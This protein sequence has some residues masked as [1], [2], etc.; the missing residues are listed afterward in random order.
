MKFLILTEEQYPFNLGGGTTYLK[1]LT[2]G[3]SYHKADYKVLSPRFYPNSDLKSEGKILNTGIYLRKYRS[4]M[5]RTLFK[6]YYY[7]IWCLSVLLHLFKNKK[8]REFDIV[9]ANEIIFS[10]PLSIIIA[11][12]FRK[13]A[14]LIMHGKYSEAIKDRKLV[15]KWML[16]FISALEKL[17]VSNVSEVYSV[18]QEIANYYSKYNSRSFFFP[19]FIDLSLYKRRKFKSLQ[20][21]AYIGRLSREKNID[22]IIRSAKFFPDKTFL[23]IGDGPEENNLKE[24]ADSLKLENV[25][26]LGRRDDVPKLHR[27]IDL[28]VYIWPNES[29]GLSALE[30]MASGIPVIAADTN[31]MHYFVGE[32]K[33]GVVIKNINISPESLSSAIRKFE[34]KKFY[35][36]C[37]NNA[38]KTAKEYDYKKSVSRFLRELSKIKD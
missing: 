34:N 6:V 21:I 4:F 23:I 28:V 15:P 2:K 31:Q 26:F 12:L 17:V 32:S 7:P 16:F 30:S 14:V 9:Q 8:N 10:G 5:L 11:K 19:N 33:S 18:S 27:N 13:K 24:L 37:A 1:I 36:S 22:I 3:L 25:R 20:T 29:F 38:F 35:L